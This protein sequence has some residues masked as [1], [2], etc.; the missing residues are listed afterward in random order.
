M[1]DVLGPEY[2]PLAGRTAEE[3]LKITLQYASDLEDKAD[4][5]EGV[6]NDDPEPVKKGSLDF[7]KALKN[8][9][10]APL[11]TETFVGR[12]EA[13][14]ATARREI[15]EDDGENWDSFAS[16]IETIMA[17]ATAD[18]QQNSL[19]WKEAFWLV[20]GQA[21]RVQR[22]AESKDEPVD[23]D[24]DGSPTPPRAEPRREEVI[25]ASPANVERGTPR[26][27]GQDTSKN[28]IDDPIERNTKAKFARQLGVE[29]SDEEWIALQE[30]EINTLEDYQ[31]LQ[32]RLN[33]GGS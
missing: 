18:Q 1:T 16:Y 4:S 17:N 20:W 31:A 29:M 33:K 32:K 7:V 19:V 5:P 8:A 13:A 27:R 22:V 26:A 28:R 24:Q 15:M 23:G 30:E 14:K 12:R 11:A 25:K 9:Q 6:D 3:A 21:A 10:T 2:G